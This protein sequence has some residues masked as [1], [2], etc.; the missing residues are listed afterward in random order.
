V[1]AN[2]TKSNTPK[3]SGPVFHT[4]HFAYDLA[5][6]IFAWYGTLDI[7][8]WLNHY[9]SHTIPREGMP[10]AAPSLAG[11]LLLWIAAAACSNI[12]RENVDTSVVRALL[13][14]AKSAT[15]VSTLVIFLTFFSRQLGADKSRSFVIL[16][17]PVS[18]ASLI[19]SFSV[20]LLT[21]MYVHRRWGS[22]KRVAVLGAGAGTQDIVDTIRR[23]GRERVSVCGLILPESAAAGACAESAGMDAA[24]AMLPVLGTT[25]HLAEVIN[26]ESLDRIIITSSLSE[27]EF[28]TC[29]RVTHRMGVTVSRPIQP[30]YDHILVEHQME[31]GLH[32]IDVRPAPFTRRQELVKRGADVAGSL[33]LIIGLMPLLALIALLVRL[34]SS[35][36]VLYKAL[37]VGKGGRYFT[38]WKFRSMYISGPTRR[39]LMERNERSGHIFKI[40][41]DPRVTPVGRVLRRFSLDE[42]PQLFNVLAGDMSLVGPRPLPVEDLDPDG[43]SSTFAKWAEDRAQVRPGITGLWQVSGRSELPFAKMME[44]DIEYIRRWSLALDLQILILKTPRAVL[45]SQGAY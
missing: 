3:V 5:A 10:A 4:V 39:E 29:D 34:T 1:T 35:G 42:L 43:M 44:L 26:R 9:M 31:F 12:Y 38:F 33:A 17:A 13:N 28:E 27:G 36:P 14:V 6:L 22:P 19:A 18:F 21:A 16:F 7:R 23:A 32:F 41:K 45:S 40:R 11:L 8:V 24:V 30:A 37:R 2:K 20:A 15:I 25:R